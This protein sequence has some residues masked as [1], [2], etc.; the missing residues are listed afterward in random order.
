MHGC[1]GSKTCTEK[2]NQEGEESV[3][4]EGRGRCCCQGSSDKVMCK[5]RRGR[6]RETEGGERRKQGMWGAGLWL[7]L[8]ITLS[9]SLSKTQRQR[10]PLGV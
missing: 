5:Q 4:G 7:D 9:H 8:E 2:M 3:L 10:G 6:A 1:V